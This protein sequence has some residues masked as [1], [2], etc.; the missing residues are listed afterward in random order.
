MDK[1]ETPEKFSLKMLQ[2]SINDVPQREIIK[3]ITARDAAIRADERQKAA[4]ALAPFAK[5]A[6]AMK[7][8]GGNFPKTGVVYGI[9]TGFPHGAEIT[10][11]DFT[12]AAT[13]LAAIMAEPEEDNE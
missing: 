13:A 10:R 7:F 5:F 1:I 8:M 2:M 6:D 3:A 11:E 9:N 12:R 4:E